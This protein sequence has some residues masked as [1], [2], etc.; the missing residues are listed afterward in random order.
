MEENRSTK[1]EKY[2]QTSTSLFAAALDRSIG[3][4]TDALSGCTE[5]NEEN[6]PKL[7]T[8][9]ASKVKRRNN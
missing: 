1:M 9:V 5:S 3:L 8:S 6:L 7:Q 4:V 2:S